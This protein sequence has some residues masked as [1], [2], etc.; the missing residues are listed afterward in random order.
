MRQRIGK[1]EQC[2]DGTLFLDEI[3]DMSLAVQA[4]MLRVLQEQTFERV[5]GNHQVHTNVRIV[6]ATNQDLEKR[7]ADGL[8]RADLYFRLRVATIA[9]PPLR[10]R[11]EDIE[12]LANYF[13]VRNSQA[14]GLDLRGFAAEALA[15]LQAAP[16][17]GNVRELQSV[18]KEAMVRTRGPIVLAEYL[19]EHLRKG[20]PTAGVTREQALPDFHHVLALMQQSGEVRLYEKAIRALDRFLLREVMRQT[21]GNQVRASEI[22]GI[23]RKTLRQKLRNAGLMAVSDDASA[24]HGK[25][26][27]FEKHEAPT[28]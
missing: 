23:N 18:V 8:F 1:F 24:R 15:L 17:P 2:N 11:R 12:E 4:K 9:V 16:W 10:D 3:A 5:G 25:L 22:L 27:L 6:A 13:L 7:V 20:S 19:P 26:N 21:K 14:W 28:S